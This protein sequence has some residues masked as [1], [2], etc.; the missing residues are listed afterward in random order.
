ML[1][2]LFQKRNNKLIIG[3]GNPG[4]GYKDTRHNVGMMFIEEFKAQKG[5][6]GNWKSKDNYQFV[7][8]G[9]LILVKPETFMNLSGEAVQK[10]ARFFRVKPENIYIAHDDL[11]IKLGEYKIQQGKGPRE[12]NGIKSVEQ[13]LGDVNFWR[14]RIGIENRVNKKFK[15]KDYVLSKFKVDEIPLLF[16]TLLRIVSDLKV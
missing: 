15:G 12:H 5:I 6:E 14:V 9:D 1:G 7:K 8:S 13:Q 11:D 4:D 16:E 3:L 10:A 2:R